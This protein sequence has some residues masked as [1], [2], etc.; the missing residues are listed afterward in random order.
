MHLQCPACNLQLLKNQ[1]DTWAFLLVF[2]RL[3]LLLP[4]IAIFFGVL[5]R[6]IP[7]LIVLFTIWGIGFLK[8]T[9]NRYGL[10]VGLDYW[11]RINWGDL[12]GRKPINAEI[13]E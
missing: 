10:C 8:T 9:P 2:D 7:F 6:D 13:G 5:P 4:I 3:F 11:T 12:S 1:G